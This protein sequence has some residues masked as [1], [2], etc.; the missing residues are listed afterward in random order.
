M[1]S[2]TS[3]LRAMRRPLVSVKVMTSEEIRK[4]LLL[5]YSSYSSNRLIRYWT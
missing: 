4:S 3:G 5:T 2:V 1:E